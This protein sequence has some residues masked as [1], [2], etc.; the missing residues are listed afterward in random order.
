MPALKSRAIVASYEAAD[1]TRTETKLI[2]HRVKIVNEHN[3]ED[4]VKYIMKMALSKTV[5]I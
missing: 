3:Q 4:I 1:K 2:P 5:H